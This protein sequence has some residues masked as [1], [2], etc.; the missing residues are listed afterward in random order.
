MPILSGFF[1]FCFFF[2]INDF[3]GKVVHKKSVQEYALV[4]IFYNKILDYVNI[5]FLY[6]F[7]QSVSLL[8]W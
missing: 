8:D 5:R 3:D 2:N 1:L 6:H 4:S 7:D